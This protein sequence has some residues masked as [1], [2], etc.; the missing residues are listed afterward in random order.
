[1]DESRYLHLADEAFKRIQDAFEPLDPDDAEAYAAGDVLTIT[2]R[3]GSRCVVNTQ[4]PTR[5][6]W[7][8]ARARAWH[9][10]YDEA[11]A[12]WLD[13]KGRGDEL[14]ATIARVVHETAGVTVA[15][16]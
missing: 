9:F 15:L 10:S 4:R 14:Y 11:T 3:D 1:M 12:R 5:Q 8:A 2:F 13:D 6:L 16:P 7:L